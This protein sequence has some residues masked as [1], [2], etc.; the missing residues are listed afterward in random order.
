MPKINPTTISFYLLYPVLLGISILPFP[1]LYFISDY[2]LYPILYLFIGYRKKVVSENLK[3]AFPDK[4]EEERKGIEKRFYHFLCDLFVETLKGITISEKELLKRCVYEF[5]S[6]LTD[7]WYREQRNFIVTL[8][9]FGNYEWLAM[10]LDAK[11]KHKGS[12]PFHKMKNPYFN[13]MFAKMR[14]KFGTH[15]YPTYETYKRIEKGYDRPFLVGLANDQ[16]AP[17]LKSYWTTFLNQD[18]SFFYGTE[19]VAVQFD[20]PVLFCAIERTKRG[21]YKAVYKLISDDP[22]GEKANSTIEKHARLLETQINIQPELWLWSHRR[23]KH[24]KPE[25]KNGNPVRAKN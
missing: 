16:S 7:K 8:G 5:D 17:P 20:M 2:F 23:W 10:T 3:N 19:K 25:K 24:K 13:G 4:S 12:G 22:K 18:T 6:D 9:H 14:M 21:Y 1:V 11:F 15:M